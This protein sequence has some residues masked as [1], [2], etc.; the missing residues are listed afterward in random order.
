MDAWCSLAAPEAA[1]AA[2][3]RCLDQEGVRDDW[4]GLTG[5]GVGL[6][7]GDVSAYVAG[8]RDI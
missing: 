8:L 5:C 6:D 3:A 2:E 7:D 1:E 4:N